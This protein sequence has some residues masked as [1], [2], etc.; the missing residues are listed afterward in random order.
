MI[1]TQDQEVSPKDVRDLSMWKPDEFLL[2]VCK[3]QVR[4]LLSLL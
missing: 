2:E 3:F 4:F 1:L